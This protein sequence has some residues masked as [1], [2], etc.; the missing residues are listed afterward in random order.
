MKVSDEIKMIA[1]QID[2][3]SILEIDASIAYFKLYGDEELLRDRIMRIIRIERLN[4]ANLQ[5]DF[6]NETT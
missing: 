5:F 1:N 6:D 4:A 3:T 2:D